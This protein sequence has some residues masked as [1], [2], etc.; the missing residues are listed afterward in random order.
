MPPTLGRSHADETRRP[1][2]IAQWAAAA[3]LLLAIAALLLSQ[4]WS[5][6]LEAGIAEFSIRHI[7]NIG[8]QLAPTGTELTVGAGSQTIFTL[9]VSFACSVVLLLTPLMA[10][11]AALLASGRASILRTLPTVLVCAT[12]LLT[13]NACRFLLIAALTHTAGLDGYGW[14]HTVYGSMLVLVGLAIILMTFVKVVSH[15]RKK[16]E[17][18][19]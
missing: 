11:A 8:S 10:L 5:R 2:S 14:A 3:L 9:D 17:H 18:R 7:L 19:S 6:R 13:L 15:T 16:R 12:A 4:D 1:A